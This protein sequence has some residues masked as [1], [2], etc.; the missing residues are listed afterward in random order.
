MSAIKKS[1]DKIVIDGRR[2]QAWTIA[3]LVD[4]VI[5]PRY[6]SD[7]WR[8][9]EIIQLL[10][11]TARSYLLSTEIPEANVFVYNHYALNTKMFSATTAANLELL[12]WSQGLLSVQLGLFMF[13]NNS[14]HE[15]VN[16]PFMPRRGNARF[17]GDMI[18]LRAYLLYLSKLQEQMEKDCGDTNPELSD[19]E[20]ALSRRLPFFRYAIN[21][22]VLHGIRLQ[23]K[24]DPLSSHFE[25]SKSD[26]PSMRESSGG[27]TA[28]QELE[29]YF[30]HRFSGAAT[31]IELVSQIYEQIEGYSWVEE[32]NS[33]D[34]TYESEL[35]LGAHLDKR[36]SRVSPRTSPTTLQDPPII[37]IMSDS[38]LKPLS[39]GMKETFWQER[40]HLQ[41]D[42]IKLQW[43]A[44][45]APL[46]GIPRQPEAPVQSL[47]PISIQGQQMARQSTSKPWAKANR[48]TPVS[49]L[50]TH[51]LPFSR[52][53]AS[54]GY[55]NPS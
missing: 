29:G 51:I 37:P 52:V 17:D 33:L 11:F 19:A 47:E 31:L 44:N 7:S 27:N 34:S 6:L 5:G 14:A 3:E 39:Q 10:H 35:N 46:I 32:P 13:I 54:V 25:I 8:D 36:P 48:Y 21:N 49:T 30:L 55:H 41:Q 23:R 22:W 26:F 53:D 43:A 40:R 24:I 45:V 1:V 42:E 38:R 2:E 12:T 16:N 15:Y 18:I 20:D 28:Q 4:G 50:F 9:S